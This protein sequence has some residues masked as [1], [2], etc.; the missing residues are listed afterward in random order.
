[1]SQ[2]S[3]SHE[4]VGTVGATNVPG[5][6]F[7]TEMTSNYQTTHRSDS[8]PHDYNKPTLG[9]SRVKLVLIPISK[10]SG[11]VEGLGGRKE[12]GKGKSFGA[13]EPVMSPA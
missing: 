4:T 2:C 7:H 12:A 5:S 6:N 3:L 1:M 8:K 10:V 9:V 13:V 11:A